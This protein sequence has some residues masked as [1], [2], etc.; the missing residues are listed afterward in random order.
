MAQS[1]APLQSPPGKSDEGG[2]NVNLIKNESPLDGDHHNKGNGAAIIEPNNTNSSGGIPLQKINKSV[3]VDNNHP[4]SLQSSADDGDAAVMEDPAATTTSGKP[5]SSI[6]DIAHVERTNINNSSIDT[7]AVR[8]DAAATT[9]PS[10]NNGRMPINPLATN[11]TPNLQSPAVGGE[12]TDARQ[13]QILASIQHRRQ[14]LAWVR[15]SRIACEQSRSDISNG[16]KKGFVAALVEEHAKE[17]K[18][19]DGKNTTLKLDAAKPSSLS[20]ST[21]GG[22]TLTPPPPSST[23]AE[24]IANYKKVSKLANSATA[25]QRKKSN[26]T[27]TTAE[28]AAQRELRRGSS[29][30]KR[31][32]AAVTTLNNFGNVGGWAST[33]T[34]V[35]GGDNVATSSSSGGGAKKTSSN[36]HVSSSS[37]ALNNGKL[38]PNK[39]A[40]FPPSVGKQ[41]NPTTVQSSST[42]STL[43]SK[44]APE[45]LSKKARKRSSSG[46]KKT[47]VGNSAD[48]SSSNHVGGTAVSKNASAVKPTDKSTQYMTLSANAIRL[49]DRRDELALKLSNLL[50]KQH[51]VG[52][53]EKKRKAAADVDESSPFT[54]RKKKDVKTKTTQS[55]SLTKLSSL[56]EMGKTKEA[57]RLPP[58]RMT[59]WDCV[60]EEMRWMASDFIQE[61]KWKV[62]CGKSLSSS[63]KQQHI[64]G[65]TL[66]SAKSAKGKSKHTPS[67]SDDVSA[68]AT[69]TPSSSSLS[70]PTSST[71]S[72]TKSADSK[73]SDRRKMSISDS[74]PLYVDPSNDDVE[75]SRKISQLL[76]L[77]VSDHWDV[78]SNKGAFPLTDDDY[79]AGYERFR[80]VRGELLGE[81]S[82]ISVKS[83]AN[84][85]SPPS[86]PFTFQELE[87][88]VIS[89]KMQE[90]VTAINSLK[91]ETDEALSKER[92]MQKYRKSLICGVELSNAQLKAVHFIESIWGT[93]EGMSVAAVLGG[94]VGNG[95]TIVGCSTLWKNRHAGAQ[96]VL[97][98]PASLFRWKH[99]LNK[100][101]DLN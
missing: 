37:T 81:T 52:S 84:A 57:T 43:S 25:L 13:Q 35:S 10:N 44:A 4:P 32:S 3:M 85:S 6:G 70:K 95:K 23:S 96:L 82:E 28:T 38:L 74:N 1:S 11:T 64:D 30:G 73:S 71:K 72:T 69:E 8:S 27:I 47:G 29:V 94:N 65:Q 46:I 12:V 79:K 56:S 19:G 87:F 63:V 77:T 78:T 55:S 34:S 59:Q 36:H 48:G 45:K 7:A 97:C 15:E 80:K 14:L 21:V 83:S 60:L 20:L 2:Y 17:K 33:D 9:A 16:T 91:A 92:A 41:L 86:A 61:R 68:A 62:A 51:H 98:S 58:R 24:E 42:S 76:S 93:R 26:S 54:P 67:K 40:A 89:K 100:F 39:A 49:R 31:M 99:E 66:A 90:S 88:D 50:Q 75:H 22:T 53:G 101:D 5:S 18:G